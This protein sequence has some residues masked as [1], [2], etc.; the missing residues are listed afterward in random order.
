MKKKIAISFGV[1]LLITT[2]VIPFSSI[3]KA[4]EATDIDLA[5]QSGQSFIVTRTEVFPDWA[6]ASLSEGYVFHGLRGEVNAYMFTINSEEK[7]IGRI[8]VGSSD[9]NYSIMEAGDSLPPSLPTS[10]ELI[11]SA[12][13]DLG[14]SLTMTQKVT[15]NLVYLGYDSFVALYK[16]GQI[17]VAYDLQIKKTILASELKNSIA[18][19]E[20][21]KEQTIGAKSTLTFQYKSLPVPVRNQNGIGY[22]NNCGPTSGAMIAEY[23]KYYRGKTGLLDWHDDHDRMYQ[24][25]Y[26]NQFL[27]FNG[28]MP[29]YAG[30]GFVTYAAENG[31]YFSTSWHAAYSWDNNTIKNCID[32]QQPIMILF[33]SG[34]PY[35]TWHYCAIRGYWIDDAGWYMIVNN[36]W[37][38]YTDLVSWSANWGY[39]SLHFIVP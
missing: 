4:G 36:P 30:P 17:T 5:R 26:T 32:V 39:S 34:A 18:T 3:V 27:W 21:Y 28:T 24:T 13:K 20:E 6:N 19:P 29:W 15:P 8:V 14:I 11:D 35:A 9:Y 33:W 37:G 31:Y 12:N 1:I 25:M 38:G 23:Y 16:I 7:K 10:D 2:L 22:S